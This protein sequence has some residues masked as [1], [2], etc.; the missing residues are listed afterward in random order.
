M[1]SDFKKRFI[2]SVIATIPILLLSPT[3]QSIFAF[4]IVFPGSVAALFFLAN[5][6]YAYGGWPFIKGCVAELREKKAGMMTLVAMAI[7]SAHTYSVLVFLKIFPGKTF[8]WE[9]ATLIDVMLLGH[10]IEMKTVMGASKS[11]EKLAKLLPSQVYLVLPDGS[12]KIVEQKNLKPDDKVMVK[13]GGK[14]PIDGII[15]D[16]Q[17]NVNQAAL[18]GESKP[19]FKKTGDSVIGGSINQDGSLIVQVKKVGTESY[20]AKIIELVRAASVSKSRAQTI[21]N[22]AA[23]LLTIIAVVAGVTTLGYWIFLDQPTHFALERMITVMVITCPHALGLAVPLVVSSITTLAAQNGLLIRNRTAFEKAHKC[24]TV[25]FDKTGTLTT[26]KFGVTK[27]VSLS[28]WNEKDILR[29]ATAIEQRSEHSIAKSIVEKAIEEKI[30]IPYVANFKALP[31]LGAIG[32]VEEN[33]IFVGSP[34]I[35]SGIGVPSFKTNFTVENASRAQEEIQKMLN[36]GKTIV[37][38]ATQNEI[39]GLIALSDTVRKESLEAC[40]KLKKENFEL[41]MITGDNETAAANIAD[42]LGIKNFYADVA[43]DRKALKVKELQ[44]QGQKIIMVGD[45]I[46]DA[47]ALAQANVGI[48]IGSGTDI[49]AETADVILVSDDPRDVVNVV[50]LSKLMRKKMFQNLGWATGY[51]IFAIPVAAGA[52]YRY[53]ILLPPAIGALVMSASTVIVAI[54]SRRLKL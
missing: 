43:P 1:V 10:W 50:K 45:G 9:V 7:T 23:F 11:L 5:C 20:I 2:I 21:A 42:Q 46:N 40:Q 24:K 39:K 51:N 32:F 22:K 53:G 15:I 3:I 41:A 54:N 49:A 38:V 28:S 33:I 29:R 8:F 31:G 47:P 12:T 44:E 30:K 13:P 35:M 4:A 14:I 16:G 6:V 37:V 25:L 17:A 26:G 19:V 52:L 34:E 36:Q 18:T 48:A 27:I